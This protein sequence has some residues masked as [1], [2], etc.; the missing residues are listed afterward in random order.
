MGYQITGKSKGINCVEDIHIYIGMHKTKE[1]LDQLY[2]FVTAQ[3][4]LFT[5]ALFILYLQKLLVGK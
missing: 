4:R 5:M 2:N 3:C 1:F